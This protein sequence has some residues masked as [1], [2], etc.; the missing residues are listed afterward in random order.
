MTG[1]RPVHTG[2]RRRGAGTKG[3]RE[4][5]AY[6]RQRTAPP[7][8]KSLGGVNRPGASARVGAL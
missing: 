8:G 7:A 1:S 6:S 2:S 5:D 4:L 3:G